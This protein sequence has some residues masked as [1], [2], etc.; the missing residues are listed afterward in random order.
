MQTGKIPNWLILFGLTVGIWMTDHFIQNILLVLLIILIFFP[1]FCIGA[2]GAGDVKAIAV[3]C[4]YLQAEQLI[5]AI[6]YALILGAAYGICKMLHQ[7]SF[8]QK[9]NK[10][11]LAP[12][13]CL[14]VLI[15]IG[16]TYL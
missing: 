7:Y 11:H 1:L 16:G 3:L 14:G 12:F 13:I 2:I 4:F 5:S 15:S 8:S 10:I 6:F 9:N